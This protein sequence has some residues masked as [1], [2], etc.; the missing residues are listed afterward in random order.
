MAREVGVYQEGD[1]DWV[2]SF[3]GTEE[4]WTRF[5]LAMMEAEQ[6]EG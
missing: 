3:D 5:Q 4:E 6:R 1:G 2:W